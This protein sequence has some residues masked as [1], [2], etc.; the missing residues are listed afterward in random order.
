MTK[1]KTKADLLWDKIKGVQLELFGLPGQTVQKHTQRFSVLPDRVHLKI[2]KTAVLPA[3]E[4]ALA[5][6]KLSDNEILSVE[7]SGDYIV[8]SAVKAPEETKPKV[9]KFG[10]RRVLKVR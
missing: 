1:E 10:D 2:A 9:T 3:L 6:V 8:V 7:Q 4:I 5:S